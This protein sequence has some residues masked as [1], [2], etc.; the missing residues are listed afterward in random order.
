MPLTC[1]AA[2]PFDPCSSHNARHLAIEGGHRRPLNTLP[3]VSQGN[4]LLN[5]LAS[6][7][8]AVGVE[9][10][11]RLTVDVSKPCKG[12]HCALTSPALP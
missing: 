5:S 2:S 9:Y 10:P 8:M 3:A 6:P 11:D 7:A 4:T 12:L 1:V